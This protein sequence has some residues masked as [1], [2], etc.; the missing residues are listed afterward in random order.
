MQRRNGRVHPPITIGIIARIATTVVIIAI[1]LMILIVTLVI[2]IILI[3]IRI[4]VVLVI[5]IVLIAI[6]AGIMVIITSKSYPPNHGLRLLNTPL[7]TSN[8]CLACLECLAS[9]TG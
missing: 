3:V 7:I 6:I 8:M 5:I 4:F 9:F 1:I 2:I